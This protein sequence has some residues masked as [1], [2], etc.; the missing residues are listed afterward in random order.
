VVCTLGSIVFALV[1]GVWTRISYFQEGHYRRTDDFDDENQAWH[2]LIIV[3][4]NA[5]NLHGYAVWSLYKAI[6]KSGT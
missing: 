4:T 5:S 1:R 2:A 3:I 6:Q